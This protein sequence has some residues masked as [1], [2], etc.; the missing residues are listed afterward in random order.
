MDNLATLLQISK[1]TWQLVV[2]GTTTVAFALS[3][4]ASDRLGHTGQSC[5]IRLKVGFQQAR[6]HREHAI[7]CRVQRQRG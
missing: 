5:I 7:A 3:A 4:L 2:T 6:I 1:A